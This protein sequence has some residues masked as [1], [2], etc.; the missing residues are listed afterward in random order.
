MEPL[1]LETNAFFPWGICLPDGSPG[2]G[3]SIRVDLSPE[4]IIRAVNAHGKEVFGEAGVR[5]IGSPMMGTLIPKIS[6]SGVD[7]QGLL[8]NVMDPESDSFSALC[9]VNLPGGRRGEV[10]WSADFQWENGT[11]S[12]IR[13]VGVARKGVADRLQAVKAQYDVLESFTAAVKAF[14]WAMDCNRR[15]F[16]VGP[17]VQAM[18]GYDPEEL[19][20]QNPDAMLNPPEFYETEAPSGRV[21]H[22]H[23]NRKNRHKDGR[24]IPVE[25]IRTRI[26]DVRGEFLGAYGMARDISEQQR[27]E[28]ALVERENE[29]RYLFDH[30]QV[31]LFTTGADGRIIDI[32]QAGAQIYGRLREEVIGHLFTDFLPGFE[33]EKALAAF[34]RDYQ[35]NVV[36]GEGR[37]VATGGSTNKIS[38]PTGLRDLLFGK[39]GVKVFR[40]GRLIGFLHTAVDIT[41]IVKAR[42]E[43][44]RHRDHLERLVAEQTAELEELQETQLRQERLIALGKLAGMVSHEIRNPL[45]TLS[46]SLYIIG[47]RLKGTD[48]GTERPLER[49]RRALKRCDAIVEEFLDYAR[50]QE[51]H[52]TK[53]DVDAWLGGILSE[54]EPPKGITLTWRLA[55]AAVVE[56]DPERLRRVVINLLDNAS[57]AMQ[58][59]GGSITVAG[60]QAFGRLELDF[61]DTGPG[62]LREDLE[63]IFEPLYSTKAF[64]VGLGLPICKQIVEQHGGGINIE[65]EAGKGAVVSLWLPAEGPPE[66]RRMDS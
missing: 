37:I 15:F 20:G 43:L 50:G 21:A 33:K 66:G 6:L 46:S 38:T 56:M 32:N 3:M 65:S 44:T 26:Y 27:A 52:K 7:Q 4:G 64:G 57:Q 55:F 14:G 16:Y 5:A 41:E 13:C 24:I 42:E 12:G 9:E 36:K 53:T 2:E 47:E 1:L 31:A 29:F 8:Q 49:A 22:A 23:R 10:C 35:E 60:K 28:E 40:E 48:L 19:L 61:S 39:I 25:V 30:A 54:Y 63:K 34:Q 58:D 59:T 45:G 18:L 62:I 17:G 11:L 51:L